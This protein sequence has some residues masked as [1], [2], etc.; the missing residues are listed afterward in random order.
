MLTH[1][2]RSA[3]G[4]IVVAKGARVTPAV[5]DTLAQHMRLE[6]HCIRLG[7]G[8]VA[9]ADAGEELARSAAG[10]GVK[11]GSYAG[12]QW[13]LYATARGVVQVDRR[14]LD[15]VNTH[16]D[17]AVYTLFDGQV[18]E[19]GETVARA[20]IIPFAVAAEVLE[21]GTRAA[22]QGV[23]HVALFQ[24][25]RLGALVLESAGEKIVQRFRQAIGEK[26]AWFNG[27]L[28]E[29]LQA[30]GSADAVAV[31]LRALLAQGPHAIAIAGTRAMD[32]LDPIFEALE[33]VGASVIRRGLPA[34]PGSL[35][36]VARCGASYLIGMPSCGVFSQATVFDLLLTWIF[37][38]RPIDAMSLRE[39]G[40]GG[41]LTK[42]MS[43]RFPPYRHSVVRG[44]VG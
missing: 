37:V 17:L 5:V 12:G 18:V 22:D 34:H 36:W 8:D 33:M 15:A 44:E 42:E 19:A 21:R 40:L 25:R 2:V 35:C 26:V 30:R 31:A 9:E 3:V 28:I 7:E 10:R 41:L 32:P 4:A 16:Q 38:G 14:A 11:V 29:P 13:P 20:K 27:E 1:D 6:V 24:P 43:F 39:L 23:V